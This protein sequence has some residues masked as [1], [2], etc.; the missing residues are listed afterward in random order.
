MQLSFDFATARAPARRKSRT[1]PIILVTPVS[2]PVALLPVRDRERI[3]FAIVDLDDLPL[4]DLRSWSMDQQTRSRYPG[5]YVAGT[6]V[7]LHRYL[8]GEPAHPGHEVVDHRSGNVLDARR[9]NLRWA[10]YRENRLN[11][12]GSE[13]RAHHL[14]DVS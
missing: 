8:M 3:R 12:A 10:T 13:T 1:R 11:T 6:W 2:D 4:V 7:R 14:A 5:A 9:I